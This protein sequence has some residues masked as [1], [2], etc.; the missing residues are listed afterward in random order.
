MNADREREIREM[1][2]CSASQ[3]FIVIDHALMDL[4]A[5]IDTLRLA[6]ASAEAKIDNDSKLSDLTGKLLHENAELS[7]KLAES[8][9]RRSVAE[10]DAKE[11]AA[12][13][14]LAVYALGD[15]VKAL[16][17]AEAILSDSQPSPAPSVPASSIAGADC[18][19]DTGSTTGGAGELNIH[20]TQD[21]GS[22]E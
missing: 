18:A 17:A 10:N 6:L 20:A 21:E 16:E 22:K 12:G 15:A 7:L 4:L 5:E 13:R 14:R 9:S 19:T 3:P 1:A 11:Q 8:E 2:A